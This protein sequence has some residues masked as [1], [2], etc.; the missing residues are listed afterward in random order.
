M[1]LKMSLQASPGTHDYQNPAVFRRNVLPARAYYI[2]PSSLLLNGSWDFHY[3]PSPE[4]APLPGDT[5]QWTSIPVPGH[6]QLNGHGHPHYTNVQYPIPAVPPFVP[7]ENP[8]GTYR[9]SVWVPEDWADGEQ[10]RLRFEGVDSAYHLWVNGSLVGYAQE[11]RNA[12]EFDVSSVLERG[13]ENEIWVRVYQWSDGSYL[14]DQDQWWLSG[15]FRD[16]HLLS[17]PQTRIEDFFLQTAFDDT[18]VD[19]VL[20]ANVTLASSSTP[21]GTLS[22]TVNDGSTKIAESST[23]VSDAS[24]TL[25]LPVPAPRKWTAETPHLYTVT[26][27]FSPATTAPAHSIIQAHGFR[28]ISMLHGRICVNGTPLRFRGVNRH[29]HHPLFGRAVP[30]AFLQRDLVLMKTHN[31]NAVRTSHYPPPPQLL[32]LCDRFGLWVIDECDLECHGFYDVEARPLGVQEHESY[33][34]R[35]EKVFPRAAKWTSDNPEWKQAYLSRLRNMVLRD[36]NHASVVVWSLGNEAFYGQNHKD[37]YALAKQ[38][39]PARPVHYEGDEKA[40]TADMFSYMYPSIEELTKF[41]ENEGVVDGK[42]SKPVV[43]CEYAHAMGNGP[44]WLPEY[45]HLF[46][47]HPRL[48]GGFVWEWANHGLWKDKDGYFAYGGDFGDEPN[49]GTFVMDGLVDSQH[50]PT[51]GL[52]ELK[53]AYQPV[54]VTKHGDELVFTSRYDYIDTAHLAV[55]FEIKQ[56]TL[57]EKTLKAGRLDVPAIPAGGKVSVPIPTVD[58]SPAEGERCI[59]VTL[60]LASSTYW[61]LAGH[62]VAWSQLPLSSAPISIPRAPVL[63]RPSVS[64]TRA[65]LTVSGPA[66]TVHFST[67][68][69]LLTGW[70]TNGSVLLNDV[71]IGIWRPPTDN[72]VPAALPYWK[73]YGVDSMTTQLRSLETTETAEGVNV[74]TVVVFAPPV[75]GWNITTHITYTVKPSGGLSICVNKTNFS[76]HIPEHI[77]RFGLDVRLPAALDT[78]R[79]LA[80]GPAESY[81]D[82]KAAQALGIYSAGVSEMHTHYDV[83][84]EGGNRMGARWAELTNSH[85]RGLRVIPKQQEKGGFNLKVGRWSDKMVEEAKH[86]VD[87]KEEDATLVRLDIKVAGVGT[88]ACGPGVKEEYKV[89]PGN[90]VFGYDFEVV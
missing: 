63:S 33:A 15:I 1:A 37:M 8:T 80:L 28:Q 14:E 87:L 17:L 7:A 18:F 30:P 32:Q 36:R 52:K 40:V 9:R 25:S 20:T 70:T 50:Q 48:Q 4:E 11:A 31:I 74:Q 69:G 34:S 13:K 39:D 68:S 58:A 26:L 21:S 46:E 81:P 44:G 65:S 82:K 16:V 62:L 54:V 51:G 60:R 83:P 84:Q 45:L 3:A 89:T 85:G 73:L 5:V 38:L 67:S 88:A 49:D 27:T 71:R 42:W 56:F 55:E 90:Y 10:L 76:G 72:D 35:K 66:G 29:D 47:T 86:P 2:P 6:W 79:Y 23:P 24:V 12:A 41:L 61:A 78:V 77:P 43:L 75:L 64:R 57:E 59:T 22:M 53:V 19:A